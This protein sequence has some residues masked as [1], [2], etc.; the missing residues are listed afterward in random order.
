MRSTAARLSRSTS[1]DADALR[2]Y[3]TSDLH[4]HRHIAAPLRKLRE[5]VPGVLV[6]CGDSLRGSQTIFYRREP[7]IAEMDAA[8]YDAQ[9]MG[10][11]EFH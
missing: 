2:I 8:G 6:D 1:R 9:A 5:R 3:H 10:N 4:D 11:R 7:I